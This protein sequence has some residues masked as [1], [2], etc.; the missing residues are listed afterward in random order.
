MIFCQ[1]F[2]APVIGG[3]AFFREETAGYPFAV[4]TMMGYT[5]AAFAVTRTLVGAGAGKLIFAGH[6]NSS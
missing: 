3:F 2:D 1:S 5:F 4:V 6:K